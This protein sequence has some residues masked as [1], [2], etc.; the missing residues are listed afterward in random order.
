M[1]NKNDEKMLS[2]NNEVETKRKNNSSLRHNK[3]SEFKANESQVKEVARR[4]NRDFQYLLVHGD[5]GINNYLLF[6]SSNNM[7]D[8]MGSMGNAKPSNKA[9]MDIY[10]IDVAMMSLKRD[11]ALV[12]FND[13]F[14][15]CDKKWWHDRFSRSV[16]YRLRKEG[17]NLFLQ[18]LNICD[19][20]C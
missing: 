3:Q 11:Q 5:S 18:V 13:Y 4:Y 17:V 15:P 19:S 10:A 20:S 1:A 7:N 9:Q 8:I 6:D 12:L 16:Y 2:E 14:F